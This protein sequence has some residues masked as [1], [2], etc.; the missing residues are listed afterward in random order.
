M[1]WELARVFLSVARAGSMFAAAREL[2]MSQPSVSRAVYDLERSVGQKLFVRHARGVALTPVGEEA[3]AAAERI[4]LGMQSFARAARRKPEVEGTLRLATTEFIG[5]EVLAPRLHELRE[6]FPKLRL[7]LVLQNTASDLARGEADLALRLFRPKQASLVTKQVAALELGLYAS[8]AYLERKG[9]PRNFEEL[10]DHELI[11]FDPKGP[12]SR[13]FTALDARLVGERFA[14][15]T[16]CLS[17]HVALARGGFGIAGLQRGFARNYQE[18][19][20]ILPALPLPAVEAWL[21]T[22]PDLRRAGQ[23]RAAWDWVEAVIRE[24]AGETRR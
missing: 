11:G 20:R 15:G 6:L 10:L 7:E 5:V 21:V 23:V 19:C 8:R 3:R 16:D 14:I 24:Y 2:G 17:A 12:M 1:N 9:E 18:L 13:L 22:H 4:E